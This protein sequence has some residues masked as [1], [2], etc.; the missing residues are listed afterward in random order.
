MGLYLNPPNGGFAQALRSE[1]YVDKSGLISY[2]NSVILTE[3]KYICVSRPRKFGKT[4]TAALLNAYYNR[5]CNSENMFENLEIAGSPSYREYL[6]KY[7]VIYLNIQDF[8]SQSG[9]VKKMIKDINEG[10]SD[11]IVGVRRYIVPAQEEPSR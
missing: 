5:G 1:I 6:N 10:I 9:S 11:D 4:M 8:L 2:A 7:D 3:Q